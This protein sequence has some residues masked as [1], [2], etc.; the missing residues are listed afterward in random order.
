MREVRVSVLDWTESRR[1]DLDEVPTETTVGE[2][3]DSVKEAMA[4]PP[5]T[6]YDLIRRDEKLPRGMTLEQIGIEDR[7]ELTVAPLVSAG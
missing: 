3:L 4:L 6:P 5:G 2:L 7:E 1:A